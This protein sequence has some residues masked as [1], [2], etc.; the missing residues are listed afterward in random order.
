M[1]KPGGFRS[2]KINRVVGGVP[3]ARI[4]APMMVL[5]KAT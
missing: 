4:P 2:P 3:P 1:D 5:E